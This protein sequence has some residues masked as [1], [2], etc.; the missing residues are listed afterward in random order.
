MKEVY[1]KDLVYPELNY[2]IVGCA[3]KVF[4][5]LGPGLLEKRYQQ[6]LAIELKN[7]G[8]KFEEQ[9]KVPQYYGEKLLGNGFI[10]FVVEDKVILELKRGQFYFSGEVQQ[11]QNY[12]KSKKLQLGIILRFT[13]YGVRFKRIVDLPGYDQVA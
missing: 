2:K 1:R 12:L 5:N 6:G 7:A 3:I 8:L 4:K 13:D 11:I 9:V 10:D